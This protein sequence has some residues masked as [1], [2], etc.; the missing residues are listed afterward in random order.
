MLFS[1][2]KEDFQDEHI[3]DALD[4]VSPEIVEHHKNFVLYRNL[5]D[6]GRTVL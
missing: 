3:F 4:G 1:D 6:N 5:R 2:F